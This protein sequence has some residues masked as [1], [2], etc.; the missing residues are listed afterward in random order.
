MH[1]HIYIHLGRQ[2]II[3]LHNEVKYFRYFLHSVKSS[4][5][6]LVASARPSGR[7]E[8]YKV[9][10][11]P[12]G[13]YK[14]RPPI[15]FFYKY[16]PPILFTNTAFPSFFTNTG[17]PSL[18]RNT[19]FPSFFANTGL[20]SVLQIPPPILFCKYLPPIPILKYWLPILLCPRWQG[21]LTN[22]K[23]SS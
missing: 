23:E 7:G 15:F 21:K 9:S 6:Q 12:L 5:L 13:L 19:A 16:R 22:D 1:I 8:H 4:L 14:Y 17:L 18:F 20:P 2:K 3:T 11:W 10:R